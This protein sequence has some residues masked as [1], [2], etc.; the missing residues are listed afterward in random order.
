ME[1]GWIGKVTEC[2]VLCAGERKCLQLSFNFC[3]GDRR[4]VVRFYFPDNEEP[5]PVTL[6]RMIFGITRPQELVGRWVTVYRGDKSPHIVGIGRPRGLR[7]M[8]QR[9]YR[10]VDRTSNQGQGRH[11]GLGTQ[12]GA[13]AP[14]ATA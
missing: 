9:M 13:A 10:D 4:P 2:R 3:D 6:L 11:R 12:Q 5:R 8:K 14:P 1:E 7:L